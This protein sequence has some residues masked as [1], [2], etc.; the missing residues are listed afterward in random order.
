VPNI[1]NILKVADAIEQGS[2]PGLGFNMAVH[3][4]EG[5]GCLSDVSGR[6]YGTVACIA[7]WAA[8]LAYEGDFT[9]VIGRG[10]NAIAEKARDWLGLSEGEASQ[11]F[12]PWGETGVRFLGDLTVKQAVRTLRL[13]AVTGKVDWAAAMKGDEPALPPVP[14]R[15]TKRV[16]E[17]VPS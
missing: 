16:A 17:E 5:W 7:G 11:L 6:H 1:E 15:K 8:T 12:Y 3:M 13:L 9:R 2:V 10:S 14:A 4:G